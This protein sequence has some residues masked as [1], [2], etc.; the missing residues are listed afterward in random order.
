MH[1]KSNLSTLP[2]DDEEL[3]R[4]SNI[5]IIYLP[6][7]KVDNFHTAMMDKFRILKL[8]QYNRVIYLDGDVMPLNNLDYLFHLSNMIDPIT[9]Q[10]YIQ[11]NMGI[12]YNNEPMNGGL[13]MLK[14][15][16]TDYQVLRK[17]VD[18]VERQGYHF[19]ETIGWGHVMDENDKWE[20]LSG[21]VSN[22]W[23]MYGGFTV[24]VC[25]F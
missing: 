14:P 24:R 2:K 20:S 25:R 5:T 11:E 23:D 22:K 10:P 13:F 18:R 1:T 19:N 12:A 17:I 9:N 4:K 16:K 6:K 3:L 15:N 8:E 7:P 21:P